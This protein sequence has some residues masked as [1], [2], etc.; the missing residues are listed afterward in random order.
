MRFL[1]KTVKWSLE[2]V[3]IDVD[4]LP[5]TV[6]VH[7]ERATVELRTSQPLLIEKVLYLQAH[8]KVTED[9]MKEEPNTHTRTND[10]ILQGGDLDVSVVLHGNSS[11][12]SLED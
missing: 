7:P 12:E 10:W 5:H 11:E 8:G 4:I 2:T 3:S 9:V 1:I 6:V